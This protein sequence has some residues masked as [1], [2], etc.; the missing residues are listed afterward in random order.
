MLQNHLHRT[1]KVPPTPPFDR[2]LDHIQ[3]AQFETCRLFRSKR[4]GEACTRDSGL[5]TLIVFEPHADDAVL[6]CGGLLLQVP[7]PLLII[8]VFSRSVAALNTRGK[9]ERTTSS[10][11]NKESRKVAGLLA[12]SHEA[13]G[14]EDSSLANIDDED[15]KNRALQIVSETV[16]RNPAATFMFPAGVSHHPDH[17]LLAKIGAEFERCLFYEDTSPYSGYGQD[18][19]NQF[20]FQ[21]YLTPP[22]YSWGLVDTSNTV[23]AKAI[24]I[25]C[26]QSQITEAKHLIS[27]LR[28]NWTTAQA[29]LENPLSSSYAE[30][31][32]H[33]GTQSIGDIL[34]KP[35]TYRLP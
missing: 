5:P 33:D 21:A 24:L 15:R 17:L 32:L 25:S 1:S 28:Y 34:I 13:I 20:H 18:F 12:A 10:L 7:N 23:I 8:T 4:V 14:L 6:S 29:H 11:R 2:F 26:Y 27:P 16:G 31:I 35:K 3:T 22:N 9:C 19:S 30:K